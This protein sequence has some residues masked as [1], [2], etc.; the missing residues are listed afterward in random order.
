[1]DKHYLLDTMGHTFFVFVGA[2]GVL[3]KNVHRFYHLSGI[4][5]VLALCIVYH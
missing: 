2:G 5:R 4:F 3:T 1:M